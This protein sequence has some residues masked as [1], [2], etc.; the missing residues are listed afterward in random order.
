[1]IEVGLLDFVFYFDNYVI[2]VGVFFQGGRVLEFGGWMWFKD[3]L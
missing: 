3:V 2:M 1:M